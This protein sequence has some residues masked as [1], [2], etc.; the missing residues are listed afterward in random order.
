VPDGII[1]DTLSTYGDV[2]G[3]TDEVWSK[4]YRYSVLIGVRIAVTSLK[5][6][7]HRQPRDRA[8]VPDPLSPKYHRSEDTASQ[9]TVSLYLTLYHSNIIGQKTPPAK[10][11][12]YLPDPLSP[13]Y[14]RSEDTAS[15]GTV[16]LYLT[17]IT[18]IS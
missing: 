14:H 2:K 4:A 10:G 1:R 8:V 9:G 3:I 5:S 13:K 6:I 7:S 18:Q 17:P 12:C 15:Q 11:P 16:S